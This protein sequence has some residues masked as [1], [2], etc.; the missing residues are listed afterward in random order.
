MT[1][2]T[3]TQKNP[4]QKH[5]LDGYKIIDFTQY[6][7]GPSATRLMAEMGALSDREVYAEQQSRTRMCARAI[8]D[9]RMHQGRF[10]FEQ[11]VGFYMNNAGMNKSGATYEATR[12]SMYPG[13]AVIYLV[14]CDA[15]H[16]LRREMRSLQ[17]DQFKLRDFHDKFL[18]YGSIPVALI[19]KTML[20]EAR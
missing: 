16:D 4:T 11:A 14:G 2:K 9:I 20:E 3:M 12:N 19:A 5:I 18:S 13:S 17:G 8:V 1:Q 6:L 10:S 7:A 15:I